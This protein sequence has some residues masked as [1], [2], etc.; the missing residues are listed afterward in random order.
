MLKCKK[1]LCHILLS[2]SL[3]SVMPQM[4]EAKME[5]YVAVGEYTLSD[6][7][8]PQQGEDNAV[9][10]ALRN[11]SEQLGVIVASHT[12]VENA[13]V[14]RDEIITFS[15]SFLK[16]QNKVIKRSI[17]ADGDIHVFA[18]VTANADPDLVLS[19]LN[20]LAISR[21]KN[22][23]PSAV[24]NTNAGGTNS[25]PM[26]NSQP[27]F[28]PQPITSPK[29][30]GVQPPRG[31]IPKQYQGAVQ[32]GEAYA[33]QNHLSKKGLF[34]YLLSNGYSRENATYVS[35]H[36]GIDW[37]DNALGRAYDYLNQDYYS[38]KGIYIQLLSP[39]EGFTREEAFYAMTNV[40]ADWN[41][42]ALGKARQYLDMGW[43]ENKISQ[44]LSIEGFSNE[45]VQY[46]MSYI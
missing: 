31:D 26:P 5:S 8:T 15:S 4:A 22:N 1:I 6:N 41:N 7:E 37:S 36:V 40:S 38:K 25:R 3:L 13:V 10:E 16:V 9:K 12:K 18:H 33:S 20:Q 39:N 27:T 11:I 43:T 17:D 34:R 14:T 23:N 24:N 35:E 44:R 19:E 45:E 28:T 21:L 46:A 29:P 42:Q 32:Q 2:A 30:S